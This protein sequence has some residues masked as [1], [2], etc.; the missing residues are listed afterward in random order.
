MKTSFKNQLNALTAEIETLIEIEDSMDGLRRAFKLN[1][2]CD[3]NRRTR[4][5]VIIEEDAGFS[6]GA[7]EEEVVVDLQDLPAPIYSAILEYLIEQ[8]DLCQKD[9]EA[10]TTLTNKALNGQKER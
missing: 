2:Q 3:Y 6:N 8:R 7:V 10:Q 9:V 4:L 1:E 5:K